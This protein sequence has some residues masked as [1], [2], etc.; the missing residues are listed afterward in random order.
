MIYKIIINYRTGD[1]FN[2]YD[3]SDYLELEWKD[4]DVAK[5]NLKIIKEHYE[6]YKAKNNYYKT[7]KEDKLRISDAESKEWF[8]KEYDF[9]LNLKTDKGTL[10]RM[11]SFW[12][13]YFEELYSAEIVPEESDMKIEFN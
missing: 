7:T 9:C 11:S 4:L 6:Y 13:G 12:C 10:M 2:S 8:V 3:T 1:S 5:E